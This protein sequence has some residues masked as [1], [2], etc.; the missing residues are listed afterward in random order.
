LKTKKKMPTSRVH[1]L[2]LLIGALLTWP[3]VAGQNDALHVY[4]GLG[5]AHDDN[6]LRVPDGDPGFDNRRGD[7]WRTAEAGLL[8]DHM[9]SRQR[10][11]ATAKLSRVNFDHFRQLDYDG[12][13]LQA[14]WYWQLGNHLEGKLGATYQ[15]VL[16]PY[17]DFR[18]NE[19]NLRQQ[20]GRF[21]DGSWRFHPS[22]SARV[23]ATSDKF[24]YEQ[25]SQRYN[26]RTEDAVE[27][28][29][30]Y[31]PASGSTIGLVAR[32]L[33]GKYPYLR[34]I[35]GAL[36]KDD[37]TQ[38]ELKLHV[39]WLATGQTTVSLLAG[40]VRRDQPS[41]GGR[42]SGVNGRLSADYAPPGKLHYKAALWRDFGPLESTVVNYTLN[43]GASVGATWD[44]TAKIKVDADA[45]YERRAYNA[46]FAFPG[47]GELKDSVRSA[48][49]RAVYSPRQTVQLAAGLVHQSRS[50]SPVLGTGSFSSNSISFSASAQF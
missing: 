20:R 42:T 18:S 3:A 23:G 22:W 8:F 1:P 6:L 19:R 33:K 47:S 38:D 34:P 26:D 11:S 36:L 4:G 13:D 7:A 10:I 45:I 41:F 12:K 31:L 35:G 32:R 29:G 46:R 40:W 27:L 5:W 24:T 37:F 25:A 15:Q 14:T 9:Y 43:K 44:A 16:A 50:G 28:E 21:F 49:L 30:D 48:S 2:A 17:T 39:N